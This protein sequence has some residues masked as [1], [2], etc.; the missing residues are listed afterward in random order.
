MKNVRII[1]VSGRSG[2]GKTSIVK[3]VCNY[4]CE[5][6]LYKHKDILY[7]NFESISSFTLFQT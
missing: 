6:R 4:I 3:H 2:I 1:G 7:K 5:R